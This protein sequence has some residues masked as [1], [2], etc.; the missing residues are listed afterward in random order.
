[1]CDW[2]KDLETFLDGCESPLLPTALSPAASPPDAPSLSPDPARAP[3][4][5][6]QWQAMDRECLAEFYERILSLETTGLEAE[7]WD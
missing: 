2:L 4:F 7:K 5:D 3:T 6:E 1:V